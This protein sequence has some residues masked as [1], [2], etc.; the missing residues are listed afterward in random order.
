VGLDLL[1]HMYEIYVPIRVIRL[2][3]FS[4]DGRLFSLGS[5]F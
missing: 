3:D 5:F 2:G 4:P 1:T